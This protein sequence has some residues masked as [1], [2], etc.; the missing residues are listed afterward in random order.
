MKKF[1]N[2]K[3]G[4]SMLELVVVMLIMGTLA[5]IRISKMGGSD[6]GA[7]KASVKTDMRGAIAVIN[8]CYADTLDYTACVGRDIT[9]ASGAETTLTKTN[10]KI[11]LSNGN[12]GTITAM[13]GASAK[14]TIPTI[15]I[16]NANLPTGEQTLEYTNT[17]PTIGNFK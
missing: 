7:I 13:T 4:F 16:T 12:S 10:Y 5:G 6:V 11:S 1:Q 17:T 2:K 3:S 15:S 9:L 14:S 8:S